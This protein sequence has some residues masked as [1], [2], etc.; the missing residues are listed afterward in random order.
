MVDLRSVSVQDSRRMRNEGLVHHMIEDVMFKPRKRVRLTFDCIRSLHSPPSTFP[1]IFSCLFLTDLA[2]FHVRSHGVLPSRP[3]TRGPPTSSI[4]QL[5]VSSFHVPEP[6]Q[7]SLSHHRC[8]QFRPCC[9]QDLLNPL[10][11]PV[12]SPHCPLHHPHICCCPSLFTFLL[13]QYTGFQTCSPPSGW[14]S[15]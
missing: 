13:T 7:P 1:L 4:Q 6:I 10:S 3:G 12:G 2:C 9:L 11:V 5:F 15:F 8:N 14:Q